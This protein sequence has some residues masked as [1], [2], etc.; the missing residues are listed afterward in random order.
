MKKKLYKN[1][2]DIKFLEAMYILISKKKGANTPGIDKETLDGYSLE[3]IHQLS[4]QL[5]NHTFKFKP[6]RRLF[7]PKPHGG[8]RPFPLWGGIPSPQDK[9]LLKAMQHLLEEIYEPL[10]LETNHGFRRGK[11]TH[12][13]FKQ[14]SL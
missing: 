8:E 7:I 4:T 12:T 2:L 14:I 11:G 1:L 10:F 3:N 5:K 9:V 13:A 6:I